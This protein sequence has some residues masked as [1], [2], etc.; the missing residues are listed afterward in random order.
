MINEVKRKPRLVV[1]GYSERIQQNNNIMQPT[2]AHGIPTLSSMIQ[3]TYQHNSVAFTIDIRRAILS[4]DYDDHHPT[5]SL[6][7]SIIIEEGTKRQ[8]EIFEAL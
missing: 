2:S 7:L 4:M 5:T 3:A 8:E 1:S 6:E